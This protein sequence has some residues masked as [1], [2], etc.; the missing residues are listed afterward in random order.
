MTFVTWPDS[1]LAK[2]KKAWEEVVAEKSAE[3]PLFA[4]VHA[5]YQSFRDK[6]AIWGSRAYLR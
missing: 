4:E 5:S 3:D 6:Y 1:E 2:F